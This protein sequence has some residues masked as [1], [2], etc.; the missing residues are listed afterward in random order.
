M[1][2]VWIKYWGLIPMTRR[3]YVVTLTM[4]LA[5][6]AILLASFTV[7]GLL[8]PLKTLWDRNPDATQDGWQGWLYN[9]FWWITIVAAVAQAIDTVMVLRKFTQKEAEARAIDASLRNQ[10]AQPPSSE[11]VQK[12]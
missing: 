2:P 7:A 8:P 9:Y 12:L 3:G 1:K 5:V 6:A 4:G 10:A 11:T